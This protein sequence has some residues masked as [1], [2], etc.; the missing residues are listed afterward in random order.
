[1]IAGAR[2]RIAAVVLVGFALSGCGRHAKPTAGA[3]IFARSCSGCHTLTGHD[4]QV[5]GGDLLPLSASVAQLESF[6]RAMPV[7]PRLTPAEIAV[8]ARYVRARQHR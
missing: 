3:R 7:R 6:V 1:M 8:V 2:S 5:A 4:T